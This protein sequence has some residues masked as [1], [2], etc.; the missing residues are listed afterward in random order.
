VL[1]DILSWDAPRKYGAIATCFFLDCFPADMLTKVIAKLADSATE[2]AIWLVAD[3]TVPS[4]GIARYR[5]RLVHWLMYRF[6]RAAVGLPARWLVA[7]D[8]L[9][10][11]HGFHLAARQDSEWGMLRSDLWRRNVVT[12]QL[13]GMRSVDRRIP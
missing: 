9:L 13:A 4:R 3:F 11:A 6:F 8:E 5:A 1:A 10:A 12:K 2:D 7:P